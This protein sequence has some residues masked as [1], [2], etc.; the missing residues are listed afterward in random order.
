MKIVEE[1][2]VRYKTVVERNMSKLSIMLSTGRNNHHTNQALIQ[3]TS[4]KQDPKKN[5]HCVSTLRHGHT[6]GLVVI[7][8][9]PIAPNINNSTR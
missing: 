8:M 1:R 3:H 2:R 5:K 9:S 6:K 7:S 4:D